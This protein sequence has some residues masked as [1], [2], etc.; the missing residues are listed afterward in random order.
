MDK[1]DELLNQPLNSTIEHTGVKGM[2]WG[3]RHDKGYEGKKAKN[4]KIAKLDAKFEKKASSKYFSIYN[5][6]ANELNST[7]IPKINSKKEYAHVNF[8]DPKN[9]KL[10][11]KYLDEY[12]REATKSLNKHSKNDIG[13]NASGTKKVVFDYNPDKEMLPRFTI[14]DVK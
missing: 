12:A 6:M 7:I 14:Q 1:L 13:T 4:K 10:N 2:K 3:V 11:Q 9:K 5:K 8:N